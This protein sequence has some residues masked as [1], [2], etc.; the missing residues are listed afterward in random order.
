M[1]DAQNA[2]GSTLR[3]WRD[4]LSPDEAGLPSGSGRRAT[5][6]RREE[7]AALAG[8]SV[9][10]VVRLEQGRATNPSE[11]VIA[12]LARALHLDVAERDHLYRLAGLLPPAPG[13]VSSHLTPGVQR[14]ITRLG[15]LPLAVFTADWTL[16]TWTPLWATLIGDPLEAPA[17]ERNFV[18]ATFLAPADRQWQVRSER[19][20]DAVEAALVADL[21]AAQATY[22][23]DPGLRRLIAEC[24]AASPRFAGL[25][26]SG[27][28]GTH[29]GD[30]KT[31]THRVVGDL[32][33]D[34]DVLT[35]AGTDLKVV[36]YT[37]AAHS[38]EADKLDFLR[39]TAIRAPAA[40]PE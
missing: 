8:L 19:G 29:D 36:V 23:D 26:A 38:P 12:A 17:A 2:L 14:L 11:Q 21:R 24:R 22:P 37:A 32:T 4:R 7:L 25:W 9:D 16:L 20:E 30:R 35:V 3:V 34:C 6:L 1:T 39:V 5:G 33:L 27:A 10:Y 13:R 15:D 18:R 31:I 40:S 28:V